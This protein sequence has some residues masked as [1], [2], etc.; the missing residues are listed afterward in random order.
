MI[1]WIASTGL[2]LLA[3]LIIVPPI[4]RKPG[5]EVDDRQQQNIDIAKDKKS[6]LDSQLQQGELNQQ[7]YD[8]ALL[9]LQTA[10][11]LDL[12]NA[13]SIKQQ[14]QGRWAVWLLIAILPL[15][16]IGLYFQL[17][18]YRVIENPALAEVASNQQTQ[19]ASSNLSMDDMLDQLK[20]RLREDPDNAQ[21]WYLLG[22]SYMSQ[23]RFGEAVTAYQRT[24]DLVGEE[25]GVLFALADALA[26]QNNGVMQGE[27]EQLVARGLE[28]SPRDPTGLWLMGLAAEQR[29]DY[30]TA[31]DAWTTLLP[32]IPNDPESVAEVRK[33]IHMV[34]QRD[35][36][37]AQRDPGLVVATVPEIRV[38]T[39][40][41]NLADVLRQKAAPEDS[42][43]V[44]AKALNGPPMP[45]AV[46][47][48][49]VRDLPAQVT[50]SDSDAM[51]PS[52]KLS[53][54]DQIVVGARV[55]KTG[56]PVA[57]AGDLFVEI[58][59]VDSNNPPQNMILSIDRVK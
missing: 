38:L 2:L 35:P 7:D 51:I 23:R 4:L 11:A 58:E 29:Q 12:E 28:I 9:D 42:V 37:L 25:P 33:L 53:S 48:L 17:G 47:R 44:Y 52:M 56:N 59:G 55:S 57:Q 24:Y 46:K 3:L 26:M 8:N 30:Q 15:M 10:L 49:S 27:P 39:V 32:L 31:Y 45:L 14:Q 19:Q 5:D 18:E 22:K 34:E 20:A 6:T 43:F 41:V 21:G 1:F 54:F 40:S 50:L 13:E 36:S 16:S